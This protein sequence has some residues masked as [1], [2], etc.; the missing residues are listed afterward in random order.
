MRIFRSFRGL[1]GDKPMYVDDK[2]SESKAGLNIIIEQ[3][4]LEV[5]DVGEENFDK[6]Y[7]K[8]RNVFNIGIK[9]TPTKEEFIK[10][11]NYALGFYS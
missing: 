3:L 11:L 6:W 5:R 4:L 2:N 9:K 7:E 8:K 10:Y 1:T